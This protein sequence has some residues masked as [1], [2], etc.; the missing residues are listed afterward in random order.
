M[1]GC[2]PA[3]SLGL[4]GRANKS[5]V[6]EPL[7]KAAYAIGLYIDPPRPLALPLPPQRLLLPLDLLGL[8]LW[9]LCSWRAREQTRAAKLF[10]SQ[11]PK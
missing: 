7:V 1:S 4:Y 6:S 2:P 3:L 9:N 8:W 10:R 11:R 5:A